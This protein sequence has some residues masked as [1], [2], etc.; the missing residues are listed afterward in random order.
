M[1][2][3]PFGSLNC[4]FPIAVVPSFLFFSQGFGGKLGAAV[5]CLGLTTPA[6]IVSKFSH[7]DLVHRF[8]DSGT[9]IWN[10][11]HGVDDAAVQLNC[12]VKS[13]SACKSFPAVRNVHELEKW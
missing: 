6:D 3:D 1:G 8:G 5:D 2:S 10:I 7:G 11:C 12:K 13:M 4:A 9:F